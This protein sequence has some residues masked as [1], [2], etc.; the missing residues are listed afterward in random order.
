MVPVLSE[1]TIVTD[2]SVSTGEAAHETA[3]TC[4]PP[5]AS[6]ESDRGDRGQA[7]G[8]RRDREADRGFQH[9]A[10]RVALQDAD[11]TDRRAERESEQHQ[12]ASERLDLALER[13]F[14]PSRQ[15]DELPHPAELGGNPGRRDDGGAAA[16]ENGGAQIDHRRPLGHARIRSHGRARVLLDGNA[17]A[18]QRGLVHVQR[19]APDESSVGRD[20]VT[21]IEEDQIPGHELLCRD[22]R[23]ASVAAHARGRHRQRAKLRERDARPPLRR[24][25]DDGV[26]QEGRE[27]DQALDAVPQ[28]H[29]DERR[30]E[31]QE[32]D[33]AREL[34]HRKPPQRQLADLRHAIGP[35][36]QQS[37]PRFCARE[38]AVDVAPEQRHD[39]CR[40]QCVPCPESV[41][42][43]ISCP[44][45]RAA[46]NP[47]GHRSLSPLSRSAAAAR[48]GTRW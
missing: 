32:D 28:H 2:P 19:G 20:V 31:E 35:D 48:A 5:E 10:H 8:D 38:A 21:R 4:E 7:F 43:G 16:R 9:Q 26:Q 18:R 17:L 11:G 42:P 37:S 47:P 22:A 39:T 30:G 15:R 3:R 24:E 25:A 40:L 29:R 23:V 36:A 27:D 6:G 33:H 13:G 34:L 41:R 46:F 45:G 44:A 14:P 1:H 12:A